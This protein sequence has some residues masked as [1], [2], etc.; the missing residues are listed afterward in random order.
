VM[1]RL[2]P[3]RATFYEVF[4]LSLLLEPFSLQGFNSNPLLSLL[5]SLKAF[6]AAF[7]S[8]FSVSLRALS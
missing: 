5:A 4:E 2:L 1:L 3:L 7:F 6:S 8:S